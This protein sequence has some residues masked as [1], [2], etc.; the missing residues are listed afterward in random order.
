VA[1]LRGRVEFFRFGI[2]FEFE[3]ENLVNTV[4]NS[5]GIEANNGLFPSGRRSRSAMRA[6][7]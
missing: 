1:G 3:F 7:V 5:F 4:Y 2:E 6:P